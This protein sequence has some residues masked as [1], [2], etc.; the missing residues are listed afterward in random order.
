MDAQQILD[1]AR[2]ALTVRRVFGEPIERD[3]VVVVPVAS[4][5]GSA[6]GGSGEEGRDRRGGGGGFAVRA[7]P[8][9]AFV[10]RDGDVRWQPAIDVTRIVVGAQVLLGLV[11]LGRALRR[12]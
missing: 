11:L 1:Q 5:G 10:I 2:E 6:G 3:G 12:R 4:V 7:R 9:G 8:S